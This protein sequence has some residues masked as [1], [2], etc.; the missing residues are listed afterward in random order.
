MCLS[1]KITQI[2]GTFLKLSYS[3]SDRGQQ[4]RCNNWNA[5]PKNAMSIWYQR[6]VTIKAKRKGCHLITDEILK[7]IDT[8]I[9]KIGICHINSKLLACKLDYTTTWAII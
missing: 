6:E 2:T 4:R 1:A 7:L 3:F 8:S 9:I 5:K